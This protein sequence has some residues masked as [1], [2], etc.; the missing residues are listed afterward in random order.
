MLLLKN[1][2]DWPVMG[3]LVGPEMAVV[4]ISGFAYVGAMWKRGKVTVR[5]EVG[6]FD[7][8]SLFLTSFY[9][10][11]TKAINSQLSDVTWNFRRLVLL[12]SFK[13]SLCPPA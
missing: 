12:S 11:L 3:L 10:C 13:R 9:W 1:K 4:A 7:C 8:L 5:D 2:Y 6:A